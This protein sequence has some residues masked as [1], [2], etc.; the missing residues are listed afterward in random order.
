MIADALL[1]LLA[2]GVCFAAG[3]VPIWLLVRWMDRAHR[4]AR[5]RELQVPLA[6][7]LSRYKL[8]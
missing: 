2:A 3:G 1:W 4:R 5:E 6:E 7:R 8:N